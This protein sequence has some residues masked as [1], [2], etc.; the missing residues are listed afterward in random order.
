MPASLDRLAN[1]R[2]VEPAA[3][4]LAAGDGAELIAARADRIADRIVLLGRE[5]AGADPVV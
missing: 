1:Q 3:A 2:G 5:G 4:P